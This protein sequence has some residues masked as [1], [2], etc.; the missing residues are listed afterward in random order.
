MEKIIKEFTIGQ[1]KFTYK[2]DKMD[3]LN[4]VGMIQTT[5]AIPAGT[6]TKLNDQIVIYVDNASSPTVKRLYIYSNQTHT[7]LYTALT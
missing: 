2:K 1:D 5:T 6:P 7:W 4:I 3:M